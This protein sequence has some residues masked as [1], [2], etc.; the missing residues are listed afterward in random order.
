VSA[1]PAATIAGG[2]AA[3][4]AV[5]AGVASTWLAQLVTVPRVKSLW[6]GTGTYGGPRVRDVVAALG[7]VDWGFVVA[8]AA[9]LLVLVVLEVRLRTVTRGVAAALDGAPGPRAVVFAAVAALALR[10]F[11]DP[12]VPGQFDGKAHWS[13]MAAVADLVSHGHWPSWT[14]RFAGGQPLHRFFGP[15]SYWVVGLIAL[16]PGVTLLAALRLTLA[17][18]HLG[19][20]AALASFVR[21]WSGSPRAGAAAG[22]LFL[23]APAR[24][25]S[26]L[27]LS[28]FPEALSCLF[29][30]LLLWSVEGL[31][32]TRRP[33]DAVLCALSAAGLVLAHPAMGAVGGVIAGVYGVARLAGSRP[34]LR[35]AAITCAATAGAAVAAAGLLSFHVLP[36]L[37]ERPWLQLGLAGVPTE[38]MLTPKPPHFAWI[39]HLVRW[40]PLPV[41]PVSL[42]YAGLS[43]TVLTAA[44]LWR[45]RG[46]RVSHALPL[47]AAVAMALLYAL[48]NYFGSRA[49]TFLA[50]FL[51]AGAGAA[52]AE[53]VM[54][55]AGW[56]VVAIAELL[57]FTVQAPFRPAAAGVERELAQFAA[58]EPGL[59]LAVYG[60]RAGLVTGS[61]YQT[62]GASGLSVVGCPLPEEATGS[63]PWHLALLAR[64]EEDLRAGR[65][66]APETRSAMRLLGVSGIAL[67][68]GT[69]LVTPPVPQGPD[70][71]PGAG[72]RVAVLAGEAPFV[73]A[74]ADAIAD[75][76]DLAPELRTGA[77]PREIPT[78]PEDRA[79]WISRLDA[80]VAAFGADPDRPLARRLF[81]HDPP[82][83]TESA[84][85]SPDPPASRRLGHDDARFAFEL[86]AAEPGWLMIPCSWHPGIEVRV[87][88]AAVPVLR[89]AVTSPVVAF[90]AGRHRVD[91]IGP[92]MP[93][94]RRGFWISGATLAACALILVR[95]RR[96]ASP[97]TP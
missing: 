22:L 15:L 50:A 97:P 21:R 37:T 71:R 66:L 92:T 45:M 69:R 51:C 8:G 56:I 64:I 32:Q 73:F 34:S 36:T 85:A 31:L 55:R 38:E 26:V 19:A 96:T 48:S 79:A 95:T 70:V 1:A 74:A 27:R 5:T 59:R 78:S 33:R 77:A 28:R 17:G 62:A 24:F 11:F 86:E 80:L 75:A 41:Q 13:R 72:G 4:I 44:G 93:E 60:A 18:C 57:P 52:F 53:A 82:P 63:L 20:S 67:E 46:R 58:S 25:H 49:V 90:P 94:D 30:A 9:A 88:G 89:S 40:D 47:V 10:P 23:V 91:V 42:C 61:Q 12:G 7:P 65:G 39:T 29:F 83:R 54:L 2:R 84:R 87:D 14:W 81:V 43:L 16:L 68:D 3:A 76:A 35:D 6:A